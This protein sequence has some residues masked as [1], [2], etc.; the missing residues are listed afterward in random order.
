MNRLAS[1]DK[2]IDS[3]SASASL[4]ERLQELI[5]MGGVRLGESLPSER[6]LMTEFDVSRATVREALRVLGAQGLIEVKRGRNGGSYVCGPSGGAVSKS[7]N[8][9]IQGQAIRLGDL[10]AAREAIEP[11]AAGQA[12]VNRTDDDIAILNQLSEACEQS[13]GNLQ[14]FSKL[15]L[16]W[17]M[18]VVKASH[19][20]LFEAFM[21]SISSAV[22]SATKRKEFDAKTRAIVAKTHWSIFDAI[23]KGDEEAARRRMG[24]HV[25]A[26]GER[27]STI[28]FT[29]PASGRPARRAPRVGSKA[30]QRARPS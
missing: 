11:V 14:R 3:L 25:T 23:R 9:L 24:R 28:D 10:L 17:H 20:P 1:A 22:Q 13:V 16:D 2:R 18:A 4:A 19:N 7:L 29:N 27:L 30:S 26:Y 6:E 12:A 21:S 5:L 15:N 8:L